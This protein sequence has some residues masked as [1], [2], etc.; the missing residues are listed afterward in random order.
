ME[1]LPGGNRRR[2]KDRRPAPEG[3]PASRV[4]DLAFAMTFPPP[5]DLHHRDARTQPRLPWRETM[6]RNLITAMK[7]S[8]DGKFEGPQG[9][10][11]WVADW[12]DDYGLTPQ[13]DACVLGGRMYP[14]YEQYWTPILNAPNEPNPMGVGVPTPAEAY[15]ARFATRTPHYVLSRTLTSANWPLTSFLRGLDDV[16]ALKQ[17]SGKDIY[18]MGG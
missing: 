11:D 7:I 3:A 18:L 14:G 9:Y 4:A 12:S 5:A 16:A 1:I 13:V 10:A 17:Q 6:M 8:V 15:W 2:S